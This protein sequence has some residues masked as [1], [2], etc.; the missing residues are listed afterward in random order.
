VDAAEAGVER[1]VRRHLAERPAAAVA[2]GRGVDHPR[3]H[4]AHGFV[5]ESA[6]VE[7]T[8]AL[9]LGDHV[10]GGAEGERELAAPLGGEIEGDAAPAPALLVEREARVD[11]L[12]LAASHAQHV[13]VGHRLDLDHVGTELRQDSAEL[14]HDRGDA[15]LDDPQPVEQELTVLSQRG[16]ARRCARSEA[17]VVGHACGVPD[18]RRGPG[19]PQ[20]LG[21]EG[22]AFEPRE[23]GVDEELALAGLGVVDELAR[24]VQHPDRGSEGERLFEEL[25]PR[26]IGES[27]LGD[28]SDHIGVH[29]PESGVLPLVGLED[30]GIPHQR[31]EARP[32]LRR[33]DHHSYPPVRG[34][35]HP[36]GT[37]GVAAAVERE[38]GVDRGIVLH[39]DR[40]G[41]RGR[42]RRLLRTH[43]DQL[44][45]TTASVAVE[46]RGDR[47]DRAVD[48]CAVV[49]EVTRCSARR[50]LGEARSPQRS[51]RGERRER[52]EPPVGARSAEPEVGERD[53][54][55]VRVVRG[56]VVRGE[57]AAGACAAVEILDEH[58]G[59]RQ[60]RIESRPSRRIVEVDDDHPLVRVAVRVRQGVGWVGGL[61]AEHLGAEVGEDAGTER[62][63][64]V[65]EVDDVQPGERTRGACSETIH[66][67]LP[68]M[69]LGSHAARV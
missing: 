9:V 36:V 15:E 50:Q 65:G 43:L 69:A 58:V 68:S 13:G 20:R 1:A 29:E 59:L 40:P 47:T 54:D 57:R 49:R 11:H 44:P 27:V 34:R 5:A 22:Q 8:A 30:V 51:R 48:R 53:L 41:D 31:R 45:G 38:E 16:A 39:R 3:V 56:D 60:Q 10:G 42:E 23:A 26:A 28:Q 66:A 18:R 55:E 7:R 62:T 24:L 21:G 2:L 37:F 25:G 6:P 19:E 52:L 61:D 4:R 64:Q 63:A 33:A 32:L 67:G 35:E 17:G 12:D 46:Q 14:G